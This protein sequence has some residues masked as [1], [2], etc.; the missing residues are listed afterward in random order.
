MSRAFGDCDL[1]RFLSREPE[2]YAVDLGEKSFV[3]VATD[4]IFDPGHATTKHEVERLSEMVAN[5]T[6]AE[7]LV[8]DAVKRQ[9]RDNATAIVWRTKK[10]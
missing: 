9:T 1:S 6:N 5:G 10:N 4:G 3:I 2:V 7:G 8:Q